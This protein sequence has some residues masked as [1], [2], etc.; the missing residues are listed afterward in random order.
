MKSTSTETVKDF[1]GQVQT[2]ILFGFVFYFNFNLPTFKLN[3]KIRKV[4]GRFYEG[5]SSSYNLNPS[6]GEF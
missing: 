5:I 4:L 6:L 3:P 1:L 2:K